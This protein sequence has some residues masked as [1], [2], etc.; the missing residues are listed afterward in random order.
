MDKLMVIP[1][2]ISKINRFFASIVKILLIVNLISMVVIV[3][4]SVVSRSVLNASI[5]WAEEISRIMFVWLVF[6]GAVLGL[7]YAEHLGLNIVTDRLK[8]KMKSLSEI[9]SWMLVIV[10]GLAMILGGYSL[11]NM[12]KDAR[13]P[14]LGISVAI[15]YLPVLFA[16][17]LMILIS[18]EHLLN[19]LITLIQIHKSKKEGEK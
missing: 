18:I 16:P 17:F 15:K 19:S 7:Y 14:A 6:S 5:A 11:V 2:T 4:Y 8:P 9:V 3:F 13:T 12:V 1:N 10:V